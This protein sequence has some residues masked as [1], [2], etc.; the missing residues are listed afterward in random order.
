MEKNCMTWNRRY[1]EA[2]ALYCKDKYPVAFEAS[3]GM[4]MK[5]DYPPVRST[6]G[7]TRAV[8][9]FLLW[10]GHHAERINNMGIP[11]DKREIY[12]DVLGRKRQ[13][14]SLE[15]RKG[16]GTN[17][18]ADVHADIVHKDYRFP[19]P[20]KLETKWAKDTQRDEQIKYQEIIE[21][22]KGVYVIVKNIDQFFLWYDQFLVSLQHNSFTGVETGK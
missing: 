15:W 10:N 16:T 9:N 7:L 22:K 8:I 2:H 13:I 4:T 6:N 12:T 19:I 1:S 20:V 11:V 17:G 21:G 5:V 18:T 3:G 14:G